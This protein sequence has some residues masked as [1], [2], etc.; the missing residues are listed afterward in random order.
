MCV[1]A[2]VVC[3]HVMFQVV[4]SICGPASTQRDNNSKGLVNKLVCYARGLFFVAV[5]NQRLLRNRDILFRRAA[6]FVFKELR[7]ALCKNR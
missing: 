6:F 2:Y 4:V 1:C 5:T 7:L 3:A